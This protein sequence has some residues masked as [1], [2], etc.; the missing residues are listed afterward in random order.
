MFP[1]ILGHPVCLLNSRLSFNETCLNNKLLPT[2]TNIYVYVYIC[3]Y[4]CIYIY[5]YIYCLHELCIVLSRRWRK[6]CP[7]HGKFSRVIAVLVK[8]RIP[9]QYLARMAGAILAITPQG[10]RE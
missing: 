3:V 8:G 4:M 10:M 1:Y 7:K 9:R 6:F 5:I 2:F